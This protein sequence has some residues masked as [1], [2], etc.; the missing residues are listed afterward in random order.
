MQAMYYVGMK[1]VSGR[2]HLKGTPFPPLELIW[3]DG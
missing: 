1:D 3:T 2:I